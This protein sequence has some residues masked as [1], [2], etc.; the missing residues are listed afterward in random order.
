MAYVE[1]FR[2]RNISEAEQHR[3][4]WGNEGTDAE[5]L[6]TAFFFFLRDN[7][8]KLQKLATSRFETGSI[9][10]SQLMKSWIFSRMLQE[11]KALQPYE[12]D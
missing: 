4:M 8:Q 9:I 6:V 10:H 3:N 7:Q 11:L 12:R 2:V 1:E 5:W